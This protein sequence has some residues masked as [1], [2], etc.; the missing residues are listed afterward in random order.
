[1]T[2]VVFGLSEGKLDV[3]ISETSEPCDMVM[4]CYMRNQR[5][6]AV[7]APING[8]TMDDL[9]YTMH[10]GPRKDRAREIDFVPFN[11]KHHVFV[12][13]G[14]NFQK[15]QVSVGLAHL[16]PWRMAED[17]K[18]RFKNASSNDWQ[19]TRNLIFIVAERKNGLMVPLSNRLTGQW[20]DDCE[21]A[22]FS[23]VPD[24]IGFHFYVFSSRDAV[25]FRNLSP[26]HFEAM[27]ETQHAA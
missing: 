5:T 10:G 3:S 12:G 11:S 22:Y 24:L 6:P 19:L 15:E 9:E 14:S 21:R 18:A 1:M 27:M 2:H 26:L 23:M 16:A 13:R 7:M 4:L 8:V 20:Y 25:T 17:E